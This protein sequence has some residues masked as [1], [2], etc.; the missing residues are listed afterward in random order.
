MKRRDFTR[1][2][3]L[4][5]GAL[6]VQPLQR[7]A[8]AQDL[9]ARPAARTAS[10]G[11]NQTV[12]GTIYGLKAGRK[13]ALPR[14]R[15]S[16]G[17][18][19]VQTDRMGRYRLPVSEGD[20][21]FVI[22][23]RGF[24]LPLN[25]DNLPQFYRIHQPS[26]SPASR[27]PGVAPTGALPASLD[28]TLTE[29]TESD[30]FRVLLFGDP[31]SRNQ[32]EIGY[33]TRDIIEDVAG[34]RAAFGISLGDEAFNDL[35]IYP[36]Q[37]RAIATLGMPWFNVKGNHDM[38]FDAQDRSHEAET[39][40]AT[41]GPTYY[42][43]DYGAAHFVVLDN[44]A[45]DGKTGA[46]PESGKPDALTLDG[47]ARGTYHTELGP[48]QV[49]WLE[50]D[51]KLVPR[52]QLVVIL[53]HIPLVNPDAGDEAGKS[54]DMRDLA[55]FARLIAGR[56]NCLSISAHT[57]FQRHLF[58]GGE[59]GFG[60]EH[61]HFNSVTTCGSWWGGM[62]NEQGI[63]QTTMRDGAPNGT[64]FLNISGNRYSIDF[65]PAQREAKYQMNVYAPLEIA[66][67][68]AP[69]TEVLANVFAGSPKSKVEM[70]VGGGAW[71]T[72]QLA[73]R[74]DPAYVAAKS[75]QEAIPKNGARK[76]PEN[77]VSPHIWAAH[78]PALPVGAHWIEVRSLDMWNRTHADKTLVRVV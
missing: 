25:A 44:V 77:M 26:G 39:F 50:N 59:H 31:Q 65:K 71:Q 63:P 49:Q 36:N 5:A 51:L 56:P 68:D 16:N 33:L 18:E 78:L 12:T 7:L 17:R 30:D 64:S 41:F 67:A 20:V 14:V 69:K 37:N 40:K 29:Q 1:N 9:L 27:F 54:A 46:L 22:K 76:L 11:P 75:A 73:P 6:T 74:Q 72:M 21:I 2:F 42:S 28:W 35:S 60:G 15:V 10:D 3:L 24:A 58:L 13:I 19:V 38:N 52:E 23:P 43:F 55:D 53:M 61:H 48:R 45:Y 47:K 57:H 34:E 70:R 4:G 66:R 32:T 8:R 62:P